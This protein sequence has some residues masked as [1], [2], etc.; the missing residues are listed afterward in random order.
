MLGQVL[1]CYVRLFQGNSGQEYLCQVKTS[2]VRLYQ[3]R[4]VYMSLVHISSG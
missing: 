4:S 1:S 3:V 2:L